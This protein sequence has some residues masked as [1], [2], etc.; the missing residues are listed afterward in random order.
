[1]TEQQVNQILGPPDD[2]LSSP[3]NAHKGNIYYQD[4]N[5]AAHKSDNATSIVVFFNE[6]EV[7]DAGVLGAFT[8]QMHQAFPRDLPPGPDNG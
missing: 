7:E 6:G 4:K 1:M 5:K 8:H 2:T 3:G